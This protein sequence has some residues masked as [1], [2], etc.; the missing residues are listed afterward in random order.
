[1]YVCTY[2]CMYVRAYVGMYVCTCMYMCMYVCMQACMSVRVCVC[3]Y[4]WMYGWMYAW[5]YVCMFV[6]LCVCILACTHINR[7]YLNIYIFYLHIYL[8]AFIAVPR[9][10]H[11]FTSCSHR[12]V[13]TYTSKHSVFEIYVLSSYVD[14]YT[15]RFMCVCVFSTILVYQLFDFACTH[16]CGNT[17][18]EM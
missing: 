15:M 8:N 13:P 10:I 1:M 11:V 5:M 2:V 12:P 9:N 18:E 6:C 17:R 14:A 4:G 7:A 16:S 3:M